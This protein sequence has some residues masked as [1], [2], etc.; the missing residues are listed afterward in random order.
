MDR[1]KLGSITAKGGFENELD[2]VKKFNNWKKDKEARI[3]LSLMGYDLDILTRVTAIQ[4]PVRIK[5]DD[6]PKYNLCS[7]EDYEILTKYKKADAQ[8]RIVIEI[9]DIVKIENIS[10]KKTNA[11]ADYNQV[12][13]RPVSE[14]KEM[15]DFD[16]DI[17][18]WLKLFT[19]EELIKNHSD[20]M[21]PDLCKEP[22]K[23]LYISEF[24][25]NIQEKII[26]FFENNKMLVVSD[27]LQG[28][29]G[30]SA[31]WIL[32]TKKECDI[33][34]WALTDINTAMNYF[35]SGQVC[36]SPRGSLT[37]GKITMQR[38]G[39]T[40]DPTCLQFKIHPCDLFNLK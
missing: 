7:S 32:V 12:D 17:C 9:G 15:W 25:K 31:Q 40:P 6:L 11:N 23:R 21:R 35:G 38:K 34:S 22:N 16:E 18:L 28:R 8:I 19:G 13:K 2:I 39:G 36:L 10:I 24:P 37:I 26:D 5:K 20:L 33:T 29:G 4:I 3:W 27:I 1:V 14:Y 30:L